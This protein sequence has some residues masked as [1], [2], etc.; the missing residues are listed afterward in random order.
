MSN[1]PNFKHIISA[2]FLK[3][4]MY[5]P[6]SKHLSPQLDF[7]QRCCQTRQTAE[8]GKGIILVRINKSP[9]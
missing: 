4:I 7:N 3:I 2:Y 9:N 8:T 5:V 6:Q 1:D